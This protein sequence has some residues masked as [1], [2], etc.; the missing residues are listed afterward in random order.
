L[1][2]A[3][4]TNNGHAPPRIPHVADE[5]P[6][7]ALQTMLEQLRLPCA[8]A[9]VV[10]RYLLL[11]LPQASTELA[12]WRARAAEIPSAGLRHHALQSLGKRGNI[13]G[14]ALFATLAPRAHRRETVRALVSFQTAYNYLDALSELPSGDPVSNAEQLH[15]ALLTALHPSA[16]HPDYY[17]HNADGDDGG[18]L[19]SVTDACRVAFACL[20]SHGA[21]APTARSA[22]ARIVDF[23]ALNL[24]ESQGGHEALRRWALETMPSGGGLSWWEGAA[25]AG[26]SLSVHALI[27]AAADPETKRCDAREIDG[28]YH[29]SIGALHSLLDSL[30]DRREDQAGGRGSL[31]DHYD[32]PPIAVAHLAALATQASKAA[33]RLGN[34]HAHRVVLT[35]M[36]SYYLSAPE[37]D[38]GEGRALARALTRTLGFPLKVAVAMFRA[39]RLAH[40][41]TRHSFA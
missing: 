16:E 9:D 13:E 18:Y 38:T 20:P 40:D 35:A 1:S 28:A 11:V 36:C 14:A 10:A 39:K 19:Q 21:V 33:G 29:P 8:F 6:P 3:V 23:Q 22:A 25:S 34:P 37:C 27:A 12:G 41:L 7:T 24:T 31:L 4:H 30:V 26:S 17:A 2:A 5:R 15:Q 32:S